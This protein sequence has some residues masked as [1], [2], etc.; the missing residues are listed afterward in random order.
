MFLQ[1]II[2]AQK[3]IRTLVSERRSTDSKGERELE[4][5]SSL[6]ANGYLAAN[7]SAMPLP[8]SST[9]EKSSVLI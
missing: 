1:L 6:N 8:V 7:A 4:P 5:A 9:N 2:N 3:H